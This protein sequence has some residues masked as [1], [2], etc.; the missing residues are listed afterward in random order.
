MLE[1]KLLRLETVQGEDNVV[2]FNWDQEALECDYRT[3]PGLT[4]NGVAAAAVPEE[5][6]SD[7]E[8]PPAAA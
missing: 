7:D 1:A 2:K 3:V 4:V 8:H 5:T 6:D